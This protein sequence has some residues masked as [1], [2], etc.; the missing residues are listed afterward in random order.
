MT[1]LCAVARETISGVVD[2]ARKYGRQVV[3]DRIG[4]KDMHG[5]LREIEGLDV[6]LLLIH[7]GLDQ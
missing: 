5:L 4:L 6:D 2:A 1:A 3:V 7:A